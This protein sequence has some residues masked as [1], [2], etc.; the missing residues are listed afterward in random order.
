M[1]L[2]TAKQ[3]LLR[4]A[5]S[6]EYPISTYQNLQ[7]RKFRIPGYVRARKNGYDKKPESHSIQHPGPETSGL[8]SAVSAFALK[9]MITGPVAQNG[10]TGWGFRDFSFIP[11]YR[12][13]DPPM[14]SVLVDIAGISRVA[15]RDG[16][17][18]SL[19][20][21]SE[22]HLL[23]YRSPGKRLTSIQVVIF[24]V[25]E[26]RLGPEGIGTGRVQVLAV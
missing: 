1:P 7:K 8:L 25:V 17:I 4:Y 18:L 24:H 23:R 11:A 10:G 21:E 14:A 3:S 19:L 15:P 16:I 5:G 2:T 22:C 26:V 20:C 9:K 12:S 6:P 13:F